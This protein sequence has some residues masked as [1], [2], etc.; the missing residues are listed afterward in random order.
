[1]QIKEQIKKLMATGVN[2]F[3]AARQVINA[4][5]QVFLS[6]AEAIKQEINA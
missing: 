4:H 1:M 6:K 2:E 3:D 5:V